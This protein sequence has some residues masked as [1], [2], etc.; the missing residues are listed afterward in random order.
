MFLFALK[1]LPPRTFSHDLS[2]KLQMFHCS[3][4]KNNQPTAPFHWNLS[5]FRGKIITPLYMI[6]NPIFTPL[7]LEIF[8]TAQKGF[9]AK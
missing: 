8:R 4:G 7:P 3:K 9:P 5:H 1:L 6:D 2:Y